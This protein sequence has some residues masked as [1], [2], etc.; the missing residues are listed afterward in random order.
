MTIFSILKVDDGYSLNE[1][2]LGEERLNPSA[3]STKQSGVT[4]TPIGAVSVILIQYLL[5]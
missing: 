5:F 3:I 2:P 4:T 1:S